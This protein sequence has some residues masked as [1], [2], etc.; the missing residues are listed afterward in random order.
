MELSIEQSCPSCGASIVLREDDRLVVCQFCD[1]NS[2]KCG[3]GAERFVLP[4]TLPAEVGANQLFFAPYLR[5]KGLVYCVKNEQ[6][7]RKIIDTTRAGFS[8]VGSDKLPVSLGLRPQTLKLR[9]VTAKHD[10]L[11]LKQSIP[12]KEVFFHAASVLD[13][14]NEKSNE[15]I[16]HRAFIGETLS[17]IYQPYYIKDNLF[18][19]AVLRK[20]VGPF[21]GVKSLLDGGG[22]SKQEWEP[23]CISTNCPHCGGKLGGQSHSVVLPC[24]N[25]GHHWEERKGVFEKIDWSV[26][27]RFS[28]ELTY[29]PFWK[30]ECEFDGFQLN[31]FGDYLNF[32]NQTIINDGRYDSLPL[33]F[34]VPAFKLNPKEFLKVA[35]QLTLAQTRLR[36]EH[37]VEKVAGYTINL[38]SEEAIQSIK[39]II[40]STMLAREH[41]FPLIPK[42]QTQIKGCRLV[43]LGFER[44]NHDYIQQYNLTSIQTAAL[45]YGRKL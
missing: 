27:G 35:S 33:Y 38:K 5:F 26:A 9:S 14:F 4:Y 12:T 19:D 23:L 39:S 6:V 2:Y 30:I 31:S 32:T 7:S 25:C 18:F 29:L 41:R 1:V 20:R 10:G 44:N 40:A 24:T 28:R 22:H 36:K 37:K 42:L 13:L 15:K 16:Y 17:R 21:A 3:Q 11:F 43:Y 34:I 45:K 8:G